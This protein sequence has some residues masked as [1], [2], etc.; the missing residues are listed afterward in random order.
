MTD[1][2][3]M[4]DGHRGMAAQKATETRRLLAG[5]E[6]DERALRRRQQKMEA[7]LAAAPATT[8][9]DAAEKAR[10]LLSLF[11]GTP[12]AQDPRR[13]RLIGNVLDDFQRLS[14]CDALKAVTTLNQEEDYRGQRPEEK[15]S[16]ETEAEI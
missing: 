3:I 16:R 7:Q 9:S 12:I 13:Q 11:A 5:V 15:Q 2:T 1:R 8:W 10:Y 4:L 6:A 14:E